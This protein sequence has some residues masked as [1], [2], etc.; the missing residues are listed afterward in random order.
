[1]LGKLLIPLLLLSMLLGTAAARA[2]SVAPSSGP[3]ALEEEIQLEGEGAGEQYGEFEAEEEETEEGGEETPAEEECEEA[4]EEFEE[5]EIDR[6]E[7]EEACERQRRRS[8]PGPG[9]AL[10]EV[11][12][13]RHFDTRAVADPSKDSVELTIRYTTFEPTS[14]TIGYDARGAHLDT[15]QRHLG[16]HGVIRLRERIGDGQMAKVESSHKL[17][18][19]IEVP[20]T[21]ASC[22]RYYS[23]SAAVRMR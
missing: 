23:G 1:M 12:V 15:A 6:E 2:E 16:A 5:G 18:V 4:T 20:S 7:L 14:A 8:Q 10:P 17:E 21:P 11:C 9:G 19:Q 3:Y 22:Q 13:V